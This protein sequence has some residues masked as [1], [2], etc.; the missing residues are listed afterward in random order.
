MKTHPPTDQQK[1]DFV[2][3]WILTFVSAKWVPSTASMLRIFTEVLLE[4]HKARPEL[5]LLGKILDA[6][7]QIKPQG[8]LPQDSLDLS[9]SAPQLKALGWAES[10]AATASPGT[11]EES[12]RP[13]LERSSRDIN[14]FEPHLAFLPALILEWEEPDGR[15]EH[16]AQEDLKELGQREKQEEPRGV[17]YARFEGQ[18]PKLKIRQKLLQCFDGMDGEPVAW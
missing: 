7:E 1:T 17:E 14:T 3:G 2:G 6:T 16:E 4:T 5:P 12:G 8:F 10:D 15:E 9:F 13:L 11:F 18:V